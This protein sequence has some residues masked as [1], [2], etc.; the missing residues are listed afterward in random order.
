MLNDVT[1]EKVLG[2]EKKVRKFL[3]IVIETM[4]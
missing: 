4:S 2:D 3:Y 1:L